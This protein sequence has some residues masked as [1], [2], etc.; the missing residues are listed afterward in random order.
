MDQSQ[1]IN[2]PKVSAIIPVYNTEAYVEEAV[3]SVMNQTLKDIEIIIVDDGSTDNS[4]SIIRKLARD[5]DRI[6]FFSQTNQGLS[7]AR[8]NGMK[9]ALGEYIHFM[10]SDDLLAPETFERCYQACTTHDLDFVFFDADSF[11]ERDDISLDFTYHRT[12]LFEEKSV[13][14][15]K[16]MLDKML[17][18]KIYRASACLNFIKRDFIKQS[19]LSFY[20]GIL[21]ED[22][23]FTSELYLYAKRGAC[24]HAI[25]YYRRLRGGSIM[26]KNFSSKNMEGYLTVTRQLKLI[27]QENIDFRSIVDKLISYI[28]NPAVYKSKNLPVT[29][30]I[31][32]LLY[33]IRNKYIHYLRMKNIMVLLFPFLVT[34]KSVLK[35]DIQ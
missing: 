7:N 14:S 22:E 15:G 13:Y 2:K 21:H 11:S 30:R 5:D 33:C 6:T 1:P 9:I 31:R 19:Q 34:I 29:N 3:R 12:Y 28:L 17:D 32:I 27:S 25:F 18:K 8:N 35:R 26:F 10:D 24:I 23:L 16:E 4:F 20:P